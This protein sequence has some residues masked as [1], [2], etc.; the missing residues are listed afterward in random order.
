MEFLL[1]GVVNGGVRHDVE[2]SHAHGVAGRVGSSCA[3]A[4]RLIDEFV[5]S[6][7]DMAFGGVGVEELMPDGG[8]LGLDALVDARLDVF[9][10]LSR[11]LW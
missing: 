10:L 2:S 8:A 7:Y 5:D 6:R 9:D 3:D 11:S 1:N 4:K